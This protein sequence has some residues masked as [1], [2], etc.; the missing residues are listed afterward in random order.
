MGE[1]DRAVPP[2]HNYKYQPGSTLAQ[3][4]SSRL[5]LRASTIGLL[6]V[7]ATA[8]GGDDPSGST[9]A[10]ESPSTTATEEAERT[11]PADDPPAQAEQTTSSSTS[12]IAVARPEPEVDVST[13]CPLPPDLP[14]VARLTAQDN[15]HPPPSHL[16]NA[17]APWPTDWSNTTIDLQ[18]LGLGIH[19]PD[20]RDLIRPIDRPVFVD[21]EEAALWL[22]DQDPG[23][24]VRIEDQARFYPLR[25]MTRHEIVNDRIG[26]R[27][28]TVTYCPLCNTAVAFDPVVEGTTLRF[29]V[30][31]LLRNSDLVMWDLQT[32]SLW[33]QITGEPIVGHYAGGPPLPYLPSA[34]VAF[35][36]F[37]NSH[38]HGC[39]LGPEQEFGITY[40]T[41]PYFGYSSSSRPFLFDGELDD[42]LP[43][44]SRVV[45]VSVGDRHRAYSFE[46]LSSRQVINDQLD[47]TP[48]VVMWGAA[49]TADALDQSVISDSRPIGTGVAFLA[50]TAQGP[51]TFLPAGDD[52]FADQE[53]NSTWNLLGQA[54]DGPLSG[55]QLQFAPHRNEFWFAWY[56]FFGATGEVWEAP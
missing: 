55:A 39:V 44:L 10:T 26:D 38:P 7:T 32:T 13:G 16:Q 54:V 17:V 28:V 36:E 45:G 48:V 34:I 3:M 15:P 51:L 47:G 41:N 50:T 9:I 31:G 29:G 4:L 37:V 49:H 6:L 11:P 18:E 19:A 8:C 53:T 35:S 20:P 14:P 25:V 5:W 30:S 1:V 12:T 46:D 21:T 43:A 23:M 42:R 2:R 22:S 56:A 27:P 40:G 24:L 52:L 33:Q